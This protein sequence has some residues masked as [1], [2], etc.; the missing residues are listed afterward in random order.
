MH[1]PFLMQ[2]YNEEGHMHSVTPFEMQG[3]LGYGS[4]EALDMSSLQQPVG[5]VA[6]VSRRMLSSNTYLPN[7]LPEQ[8]Q[9]GSVSVRGTSLHCQ[10]SSS[11]VYSTSAPLRPLSTPHLHTPR[12]ALHREHAG[13]TISGGNVHGRLRQGAVPNDD[14]HRSGFE[15]EV[16]RLL[17]MIKLAQQSPSEQPQLILESRGPTT[18]ADHA[19]IEEPFKSLAGFLTFERELEE[20]AEKR[21]R[22]VAFM[23]SVGGSSTREKTFRVLSRL[24]DPCVAR[25]FSL[26]G[27]KKKR[28]FCDLRVW[29][30]LCSCLAEYTTGATN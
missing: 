6:S 22:L 25:E 23:K 2:D 10:A 17:H 3:A 11:D 27:A 21:D 18:T 28:R 9:W 30:V 1:D 16:I 19:L 15:K 24:L 13:M 4:Q 14:G 8:R 20:S 12:Q 5:Q 7:H 29:K 26:Y